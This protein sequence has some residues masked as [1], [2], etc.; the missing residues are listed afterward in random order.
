MSGGKFY[1]LGMEGKGKGL[2]EVSSSK[3]FFF[4]SSN[5]FGFVFYP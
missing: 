1:F 3:C 4:F 2:V 5:L